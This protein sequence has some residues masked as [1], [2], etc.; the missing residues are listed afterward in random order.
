PA[1]DIHNAPSQL[2][3]TDKDKDKDKDGKKLVGEALRKK[4][5]EDLIEDMKYLQSPNP[6]DYNKG[7]TGRALAA[8][9]SAYDDNFAAG[10]KKIWVIKNLE[11]KVTDMQFGVPEGVCTFFDASYYIDVETRKPLTKPINVKRVWYVGMRQ[12]KGSDQWKI[13]VIMGAASTHKK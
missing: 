3:D 4:I 8:L 6:H 7:F 10:K 11:T 2:Q 1:L 12:D 9:Q 13:M 5:N